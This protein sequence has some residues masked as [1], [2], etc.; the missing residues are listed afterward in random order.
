MG[1][2]GPSQCP[3]VG[4]LYHG[5]NPLGGLSLLKGAETG[6]QGTQAACPLSASPWRSGTH[7][8]L[9]TYPGG[10]GRWETLCAELGGAWLPWPSRI[11]GFF[12]GRQANRTGISSLWCQRGD[13]ESRGLVPTGVQPPPRAVGGSPALPAANRGAGSIWRVG[14]LAGSKVLKESVV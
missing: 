1:F 3:R 14:R 10:G 12:G 2:R 8:A 11:P 13:R 5:V 9:G 4:F 7:T 6:P